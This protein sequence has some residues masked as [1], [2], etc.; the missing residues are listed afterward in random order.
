MKKFNRGV[1]FSAID[2]DAKNMAIAHDI[3]LVIIDTFITSILMG[4]YALK[5]DSA[6]LRVNKLLLTLNLL[7]GQ[8]DDQKGS[9]LA[10]KT[11]LAV[12]E[13]I[14]GIKRDSSGNI[15]NVDEAI[16]ILKKNMLY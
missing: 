8:I 6:Q 9:D 15:V 11:Q 1:D 7:C 10:K 2:V 4:Q 14:Y 5:K 3:D 13:L 12:L 16:E